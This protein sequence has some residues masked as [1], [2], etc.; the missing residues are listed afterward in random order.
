MTVRLLLAVLML[1]TLARTGLAETPTLFSGTWTAG[2]GLDTRAEDP[3]EDVAI[4][5]N[6]LDLDLRHPMS[7][8]VRT[9][10]SARLWHGA[11]V[12]HESGSRQPAFRSH[13][14]D[15][16][17]RYD[18][19]ADLRE[20]YV[21]WDLGIG[22]VTVGRDIVQWGALEVQ[23]PLR[24][25]N[26]VDFSQGLFG[27]LGSEDTNAMAD[28]MVRLNRPL[29]DGS[30]DIVYQPFFTQHRF[31]PFA[32][33]AA[34]VRQDLG[35]AIPQAIYPLLRRADLRLDRTLGEALMFGLQPPPAT[36]LDG[37]LATRWKQRLG[38]W[39]M[40][41]AAI[42]NW[43]R[44][45]KL[46]FDP[47]IAFLLGKFADAGFDRDKQ[48]QAAVDPEVTAA[49]ERVTAAHKGPADLVRADWQRRL[50]LG[51]EASGEVADGWT[52]RTDVAIAPRV[53]NA[54]GRVLFDTQFR[55]VVTGL[56]TA[57]GGVEYQREDWLV[58]LVECTYQWAI[59]VPRGTELFLSARHQVTAV[60]ALVLRLGEGQPWTV[61]LGGMYG[62]T[63]GDYALA[64]HLRYEFAPGW[65]AGLGAALAGG[66]NASPGGLFRTDDQ[67]VVDLRK[68]F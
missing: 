1:S 44:L 67:V 52:L 3:L 66:P 43:D 62:V 19:A 6:R 31:S 59:D 2:L 25:L 50:T 64:P 30:L 23:S 20:A 29:G 41:L 13:W 48:I 26:P 8:T 36:P 42:F 9:R 15:F 58:A 5:R 40:G 38:N 68:A 56:L 60:G 63:L 34:M 11:A 24:I 53:G 47:D 33:D 45:P 7:D 37:A 18:Q 55:P 61:Q 16:G 28:F 21:Q 65:K 12:G 51:V 46:T 17:M 32:T 27:A 10:I 57:G 49:Q 39:D 4:L 35:P 22:Q 54:L 14:P